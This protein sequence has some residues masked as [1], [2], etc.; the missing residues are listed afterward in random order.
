MLVKFSPY[1]NTRNSTVRIYSAST[2]TALGEA[3]STVKTG[4]SMA[5]AISPDNKILAT[6][7]ND[8]SI[9]LYDMDTRKMIHKPMTGH[10]GVCTSEHMHTTYALK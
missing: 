10:N 5:I 1:A 7:N 6:G 4:F 9:I 2:G 3:C 8:S